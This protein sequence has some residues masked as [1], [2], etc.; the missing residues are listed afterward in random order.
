VTRSIRSA[1]LVGSV[2]TMLACIAFVTVMATG[3]AIPAPA[4]T[5]RVTVGQHETDAPRL[6]SV[7]SGGT[8]TLLRFPRDWRAAQPNPMSGL[9][10]KMRATTSRGSQAM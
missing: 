4:T 3:A 8:R 1:V 5:L 6:L 10:A 2:L 7:Y 9:Q